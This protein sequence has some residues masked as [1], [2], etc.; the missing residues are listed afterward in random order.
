MSPLTPA[1]L[2]A[3]TVQVLSYRD[4]RARKDAA[5]LAG[6]WPLPG[7][8]GYGG[9]YRTGGYGGGGAAGAAG[10]AANGGAAGDRRPVKRSRTEMEAPPPA[11]PA[12]AAEGAEG[13]KDGLMQRCTIM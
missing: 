11:A 6:T 8:Y 12:G 10:A 13:H 9:G 4:F 2:Y 1:L 5:L 3:S 7:G